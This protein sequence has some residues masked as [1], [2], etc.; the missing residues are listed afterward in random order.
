MQNVK[1]I[2]SFLAAIKVK[3]FWVEVCPKVLL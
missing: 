3:H 1:T 2:E